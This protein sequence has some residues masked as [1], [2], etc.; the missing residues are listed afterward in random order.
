MI[1]DCSFSADAKF[2]EKLTFLTPRY[3]HVRGEY[4]NGKCAHVNKFM[5]TNKHIF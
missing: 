4:A 2:P 1:G 5:G 3:V